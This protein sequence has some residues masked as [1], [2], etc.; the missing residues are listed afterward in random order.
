MYT[1]QTVLCSTREE[2][3]N[4]PTIFEGGWRNQKRFP[5]GG[6]TKDG[7]E[8]KKIS[9]QRG[10]LAAEAALHLQEMFP[11]ESCLVVKGLL[12]V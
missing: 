8:K 4:A 3:Q 5:E 1:K 9:A 11:L 2:R 7:T 10:G 12:K 6:E